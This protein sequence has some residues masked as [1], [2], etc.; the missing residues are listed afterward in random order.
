MT[1][2]SRTPCTTTTAT[3]YIH[4]EVGGSTNTRASAENCMT[5]SVGDF[6]NDE[7]MD[8]YITNTGLFGQE[9]MLFRNN[10]PFH[11]IK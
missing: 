4:E 11:S 1:G 6:D 2:G 3:A 10:D 9:G 5:A 8:I 7:D